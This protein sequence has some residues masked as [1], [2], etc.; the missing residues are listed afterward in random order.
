MIIKKYIAATETQAI[1]KAKEEL[2]SNAVV[3]NLKK[4]K[5]RGF[6]RLFSKPTVEITAAIDENTTVMHKQKISDVAGLQKPDENTNVVDTAA[7]EEKL[8]NLASLL[9]QRMAT[10]VRQD[11][12]EVLVPEQT[13]LSRQEDTEKEQDEDSKA[14]DRL[15]ELVYT[16]LK[17]NEVNDTYIQTIIEDLKTKDSKASID[18]LLA[19]V[20]QKLVLKLGEVHK[21]KP[22]ADMTQY[23]FFVGPTGVGKTTTIAKLAAQ[24]KLNKDLKVALITADTYR[25]AAEEQLKTY[26]GIMSIPVDIVYTPEE[27]KKKM[28]DY[29]DYDL[30]F[31]DTVGHSYKN[32]EQCEQIQM[33]LDTVP[34]EQRDVFLVLS[35]TTK[36]NDLLRIAKAY[37][38]MTKYS[39]IFTKL[40]ETG[41]YGN[42]LNLKL[43][44]GEMLSYV[45][46]GQNVPDDLGELNAQEIAKQM[47]GGCD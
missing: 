40:D 25:I 16:Q 46:W 42:L 1:M 17:N 4:I 35:A 29:Q 37:E 12:A 45:G 15:I 21:I 44:T 32:Q 13:E 27:L 14:R 26:A 10:E 23:L 5:P 39:I 19:V 47:L 43:A 22:V 33:L 7:I 30:V 18:E 34:A 36:Y 11:K 24:F 31:V 6:K 20:Y 9:E 2:G 8:N 41:A 3:M 38:T 28:P